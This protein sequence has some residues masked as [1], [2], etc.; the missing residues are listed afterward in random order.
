MQKYWLAT[1]TQ[2]LK[3]GDKPDRMTCQVDHL[4]AIREIRTLH[5]PTRPEYPG[6]RDSFEHHQARAEKDRV[7]GKHWQL[8][9]EVGDHRTQIYQELIDVDQ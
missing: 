8:H 1:G 2:H 7:Q 9:A 5:S 4:C 6:V 3:A